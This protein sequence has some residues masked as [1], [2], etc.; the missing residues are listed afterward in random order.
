MEDPSE[1][2]P[3]ALANWKM[4]MTVSEDVAFVREFRATIGDLAAAVDIVLCPPYTALQ[5]MAQVLA[6]TSI[7][8]GA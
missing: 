1:R 3:F 4:A 6:G 8:L 2:K 7:A 5:P